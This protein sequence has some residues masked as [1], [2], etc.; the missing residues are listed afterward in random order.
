MMANRE[1]GKN[2]AGAHLKPPMQHGH[3]PIKR[4]AEEPFVERLLR[5]HE[6]I[7]LDETSGG[8][9]HG[10]RGGKSA[11]ITRVLLPDTAE[12]QEWAAQEVGDE[13]PVDVVSAVP[14][15][16]QLNVDC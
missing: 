15:V 7:L 8:E 10:I 11:R 3:V 16:I 1:A 2:W 5:Y 14:H 12:Q 4:Q 9:V 13:T 6:K